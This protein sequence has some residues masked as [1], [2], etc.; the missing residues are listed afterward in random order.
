MGTDASTV[1]AVAA[2]AVAFVAL[3]TAFAQAL[4]QYLVSGQLIR[5]CDS[6]VYGNLPGQGHRIWQ[7]S[8]FRFRVVYSIPQIGLSPS[9][10]LGI[11]SNVRA[12]KNVA[13]QL[14][15]LS[16]SSSR[17]TQSAL[18]GEASWVSFTRTIQHSCDRSLRYTM[19]EGDA[20]RCP[21]DLPVVPMQLSMRDVVVAA[22][23]AGMHCTDV[24]FQS[25]ALSMQGEAG[26]I[27]S[28]R[29]PVLGSLIHFAPKEPL[30]NHGI[31]AKN[32]TVDPQWVARMIGS[33]TVAGCRYGLRDRRH[34]EEDESSWIQSTS[35]QTVVKSKGHMVLPSSSTLRRRRNSRAAISTPADR[36]TTVDAFG[37]RITP[38]YHRPQDGEWSFTPEYH[39]P[40]DGEWSFI[41]VAGKRL[42]K[43]SNMQKRQSGKLLELPV[44]WI[45]RM[46]SS[47][48]QSLRGATSYRSP[49]L[50]TVLPTSEPKI[51]HSQ[52]KETH[53]INDQPLIELRSQDGNDLVINNESWQPAQTRVRGENLTAYAADGPRLEPERPYH[54]RDNQPNTHQMLLEGRGNSDPRG[55]S[56]PDTVNHG[57]AGPNNNRDNARI[58][59]V[60][61][62]WQN[63]FERRRRN[64][65]RGRSQ[66]ERTALFQSRKSRGRSNIDLSGGPVALTQ[67]KSSIKS[68][69]LRIKERGPETSSDSDQELDSSSSTFRQ[70]DYSGSVGQSVRPNAKVSASAPHV[71]ASSPRRGRRRNSSLAKEPKRSKLLAYGHGPI[72]TNSEPTHADELPQRVRAGSRVQRT[73]ARKLRF[74]SPD[75]PE[76]ID[77]GIIAPTE[78]PLKMGIS[79]DALSES[80]QRMDAGIYPPA[81]SSQRIPEPKGILRQPTEKF[82][83][84][85]H[86][87]REGVAPRD[88]GAHGVPEGARW[89]RID[90]RLVNP[91]SLELGN[92]RYVERTDC[93]IVLRVLSKDEIEQFAL[94]TQEIR[95][96][97]G[98]KIDNEATSSSS[99]TENPRFGHERR[100]SGGSDSSGVSFERRP[101]EGPLDEEIEKQLLKRGMTKLPKRLV[102]KRALFELGYPFEEK[103]DIVIVH[104]ALAKDKIDE[105][106]GLSREMNGHSE[107]GAF[108]QKTTDQIKG[109]T[110]PQRSKSRERHSN[111]PFSDRLEIKTANVDRK[112]APVDNGPLDDERD[113][114]EH[115]KLDDQPLSYEEELVIIK[116]EGVL[117]RARESTE[118]CKDII[119]T[120]RFFRDNQPSVDTEVNEICQYVQ[121]LNSLLKR[122]LMI[123]EPIH[124]RKRVNEFVRS[125]VDV[126]VRGL[127]VSFNMF[128]RMFGLFEITSLHFD[129]RHRAWNDLLSAFADQYSCSL[130]EYLSV[131]CRYGKE[132][133]A[134]LNAGILSSPESNLLRS[135]L[136]QI[137]KFSK[138]SPDPPSPT[139]RSHFLSPDNSRTTSFVH[140]PSLSTQFPREIP[141]NNEH[142]GRSMKHRT[143]FRKP[144]QAKLYRKR[145]VRGGTNWSRDHNNLPGGSESDSST[146]GSDPISTDSTLAEPKASPTG[147][148]NW[149]WICQADVIPGF[150]ATPWKAVFSEDICIGAVS[151][152]LCILERFTDSSNFGYVDIQERCQAWIDAGRST[153]PSYAHNANGGVV[154]S[155][156]YKPVKFVSLETQIPPIELM[157]SYNHQVDRAYFHSTEIVR[158]N[159]GELMGLDSWLSICGRLSEISGGPTNLLRTLPTLVQ[160][161]MTEFNLEFSSLDRTSSDG[162][163]RIIQT[164]ADSLL[165][166]FVE[167]GLSSPEQLFTT[168]A[169]LRTAKVALCVARGSDTSGLTDILVHDVQVYMA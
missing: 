134:N 114:A 46:K 68:R 14:P 7:F 9:L 100:S 99:S 151:V 80:P 94:K 70:Q 45:D 139:S 35:I 18:A 166:L 165:Q 87:I 60:V 156:I 22:I 105:I 56:S 73:P 90:R 17:T 113:S 133:V 160:R 34:F 36:N 120:L 6:V 65:S 15:S 152:T 122:C 149:L 10:W 93:V 140:S 108:L 92:E 4:Q 26:T 8:Q 154:V 135:R 81:T 76:S 64:R 62:K 142:S 19:V 39:R 161:I 47:L 30:G 21:A 126:L 51:K 130:L 72:E 167:Q 75:D 124:N 146:Y 131:S 49:T 163:L 69:Q 162:G 145:P 13:E 158:E 103:G 59:Y 148:M 5:I 86:P 96:L 91:E 37:A 77:P 38:E 58:D 57:L 125:E 155:G 97:R 42:A 61:Y 12:S 119:V 157:H 50:N 168:V 106:V 33:I 2:L 41:E 24:S 43:P 79:T 128:D 111:E 104:K 29:H 44:N 115:V 144:R 55:S 117:K 169:L 89:T 153:Y 85:T 63:I 82:P 107:G 71:A 143:G 27:T 164:I 101:Y 31:R 141:E 138:S 123:V 25:Q 98:I 102:N 84:E 121:A 132:I 20:D 109:S 110:S 74:V 1:A 118:Q 159:L 53:R 112:P 67:S 11:S 40:Q 16:V 88:H 54:E 48:R 23:M 32:G 28:S 127:R 137:A 136:A 78:S 95:G 66:G 83:E 129:E 52:V 3:L 150:L 147:E 116:T